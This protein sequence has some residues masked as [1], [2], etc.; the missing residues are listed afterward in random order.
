MRFELVGVPYTSTAEPGGIARAID[1]LRA[2]GLLDR[3]EA[4]GDVHDA[5]DL[6]LI[7]GDG[8]R[9]ASGFLHEAA[10]ARL[11]VA[12]RE[13]VTSSHDCHR[14]PLLVG[15]DCPVLLGALA[16]TRDRHG[17]CGLMLVDGHEDAWPPSLVAY[18]GGLG[19]RGGRGTRPGGRCAARTARSPD[20]TARTRGRGHARPSRS[21]RAR[22]ERSALARRNRGHVPRRWRGQSARTV[23]LCARSGHRHRLG[24]PAFWL[25]LDLDVLRSEE[26]AAVDYPQPGGLTW[27]E[28]REVGASALTAPECAGVS[29]A[30]YNPDKDH[31]REGAERIVRFAADLVAAVGETS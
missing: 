9:G 14:L 19:L 21:R 16:A 12:T 3:L 29:I 13:A 30:I 7:E 15:G 26:L 22:R 10:L 18:R 11:V 25:H 24:A 17:A 20:S 5:G 27:Q 4:A 6:A 28:L 31:D 8:L 23:L 2:A 1:V